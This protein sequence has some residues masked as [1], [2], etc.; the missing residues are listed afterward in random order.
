[1]WPLKAAF[2][3]TMQAKLA[4]LGF[5]KIKIFSNKASNFITSVCDV[6]NKIWSCDS[7]LMAPFSPSPHRVKNRVRQPAKKF[8]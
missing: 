4:G 3:L 8:M 7:N 1:M 6:N 5:F 2:N